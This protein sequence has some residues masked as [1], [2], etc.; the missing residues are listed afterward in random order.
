M[1]NFDELC[2]LV[3]C[4]KEAT[5]QFTFKSGEFDPEV[6]KFNDT[7]KNIKDN[8]KIVKGMIKRRETLDKA[9]N[10]LKQM[11]SDCNKLDSYIN[12]MKNPS[13][14]E[15]A[16]KKAVLAGA[17]IGSIALDF[18]DKLKNKYED[19]T[20]MNQAE[21]FYNMADFDKSEEDTINSLQYKTGMSRK[22]KKTLKHE[23]N[24]FAFDINKHYGDYALDPKEW[25]KNNVT[26]SRLLNNKL[27]KSTNYNEFITNRYKE[28]NIA[29][30]TGS[31]VG[32]IAVILLKKRQNA[33]AQV[34]RLRKQIAKLE[35]LLNKFS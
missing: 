9:R 2:E 31:G 22:E 27:K 12:K 5:Y 21:N 4:Y 30:L 11:K 32:A 24:K 20:I 28:N 8:I 25:D 7:V 26:K 13:S 3:G 29:R 14:L 33:H 1:A 10:I 18:L 6:V 16:S 17:L 34:N 19:K 23:R 35:I 15:K